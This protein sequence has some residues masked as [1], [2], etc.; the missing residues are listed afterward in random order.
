M[1]WCSHASY[2]YVESRTQNHGYLLLIHVRVTQVVKLRYVHIRMPAQCIYHRIW[3]FVY[4]LGSIIMG[5]C[6]Y[7]N[8]RDGRWVAQY[9]LDIITGT[10]VW[11]WKDTSQQA[12]SSSDLLQSSTSCLVCWFVYLFISLHQLLI[13]EWCIM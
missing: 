9:S 5:C 1:P 12:N 7:Y 10:L 4:I 8:W 3:D 11:T 2:S 6:Y 13:L